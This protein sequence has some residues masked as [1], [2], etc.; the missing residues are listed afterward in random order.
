MPYVEIL[1]PLEL[2]RVV[3]TSGGMEPSDPRGMFLPTFRYLAAELGNMFAD[4]RGYSVST[5]GIIGKWPG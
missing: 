4:G 3:L 2:E 1:N 5:Y